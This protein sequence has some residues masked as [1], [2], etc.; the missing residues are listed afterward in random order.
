MQDRE[1]PMAG[2]ICLVTGAT[3]GIGAATA[4]FLAGQGARVVGV[5][6][7]R[8]KCTRTNKKIILAT[9]N[10]VEF[11]LADLSVQSQVHELARLFK[12]NHGRLDVL[13]NNA[14]ARFLSRSVSADGFEMTFA[15][16]HL[17]SFL[18][19]NLLLAELKGSGHGRIINVASDAHAACTGINFDDLQGEKRF[20]GKEAYA[21]SKLATLL[22]TYQLVRELEGTGIT[23]NAVDPGNVISGFSRNNGL[24]SW[25]SHII[26][27]L[28]SGNLVGPAEGANTSIY[29][30]TSPEV[31]SVSGNYFRDKKA[32][33][34]SKVSYDADAARR[35]WEVSLELTH[36][37]DLQKETATCKDGRVT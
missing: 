31:D 34:S 18:L 14:G 2:K 26:G 22:F 32:T 6:R 20:E 23:V 28:L 29:L 21:Q 12:R 10:A 27:S 25:A 37:K 36:L 11:L 19:T 24:V 13:V 4:L 7:N 17:A 3:S 9:G 5:G 15:L 1:Q 30:A 16:N 35:L 8:E 33:R